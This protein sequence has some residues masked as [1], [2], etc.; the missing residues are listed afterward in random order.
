L[1]LAQRRSQHLALYANVGPVLMHYDVD[2]ANWP[3]LDVDL[4]V[5]SLIHPE[6][7]IP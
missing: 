4:A 6:S 3:D 7:A 1:A 5:E 2:P